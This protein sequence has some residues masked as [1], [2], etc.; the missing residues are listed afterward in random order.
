MSVASFVPFSPFFHPKTT[1]SVEYLGL[2]SPNFKANP[3]LATLKDDDE[4]LPI[5][6]ATSYNH[7]QIVELLISRRDFDPDV[8]DASGWTPLMIASSLR[9][10]DGLVDMLLSK[11]AD[12][13][14]KNYSGQV[15]ALSLSLIPISVVN[16][17]FHIQKRLLLFPPCQHFLIP[18]QTA[19]HFTASKNNVDTA[20]NLVARGASARVK[21][22]RGQLPLHRAAAIGSVPMVNLLLEKNSPLNATDV[23]GLTALHHGKFD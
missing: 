9:E 19:L 7:P 13:N 22:K 8:Q 21:D 6:W 5:H 15:S 17:R 4:R 12:V 20:R 14:M 16:R 18:I 3:K 10:E 23:S 11:D 2:N 1:K